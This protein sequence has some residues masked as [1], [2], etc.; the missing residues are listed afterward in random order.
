MPCWAGYRT[1]I[2]STISSTSIL[3]SR[4]RHSR[5]PNFTPG[6][7]LSEDTRPAGHGATQPEAALLGR[8]AAIEDLRVLVVDLDPQA[9][10]NQAYMGEAYARLL[11][12]EKPSIVEVF[13]G[14]RFIRG[15]RSHPGNS[16][17][18]GRFATE[19]LNR[20][21]LGGDG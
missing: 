19:F 2:P 18:F 11:Q 10:L 15:D 17:K 12:N 13:N 16:L 20:L 6:P 7:A 5:Q 9:N 21:G 8:R 1:E 4:A 3:R 14:Y